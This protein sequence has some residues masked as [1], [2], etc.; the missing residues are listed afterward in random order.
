MRR[1]LES[2]L[3]TSVLGD[4]GCSMPSTRHGRAT[5][6]FVAKTG[7]KTWKTQKDKKEAV[8][9]PHIETVLFEGMYLYR[10]YSLSRELNSSQPSRGIVLLQLAILACCDASQSAT[11]SSLITFGAK[12]GR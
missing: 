11:G 6:G 2:F 3:M 4:L 8:W 5:Q 1:P 9:P 7:R 10:I 12:R